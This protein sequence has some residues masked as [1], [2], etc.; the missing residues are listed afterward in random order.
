M[1]RAACANEARRLPPSELNSRSGSGD[2]A[3][4]VGLAGQHRGQPGQV[5]VVVELDLNAPGRL[6]SSPDY[7]HLAL[8]RAL[9]A[10]DQRLE[11]DV[12][13]TGWRGPGLGWAL[14]RHLFG[15]ARRDAAT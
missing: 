13:G 2:A 14:A 3:V 7:A 1:R 12:A 6:A 5:V 9:Q 11:M 15:A 4:P 10:F 8:E